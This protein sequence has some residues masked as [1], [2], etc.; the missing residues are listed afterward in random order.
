MITKSINRYFPSSVAAMVHQ[1]GC[2][3]TAECD[4]VEVILHVREDEDNPCMAEIIS[5][6]HHAEIGLT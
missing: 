3:I 5:G 4:G 2:Q 1:N 6:M